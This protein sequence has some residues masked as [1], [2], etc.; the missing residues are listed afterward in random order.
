MKSVNVPCNSNR[1]ILFINPSGWQ[2]ES[3]NIGISYLASSLQEKD[4]EVLILDVNRY[5]LDDNEMLD[6]VRNFDPFL[7][8]I[9]VKTATAVEGGR[10]ADRIAKTLPDVMI[11]AGGPHVTLCSE[12]YLQDNPAVTLGVLG[13]A[14]ES[15]VDL[16]KAVYN[17]ESVSSLKGIATRQGDKI[18]V[19]AWSPPENLDNLKFPNLDVIDDFSWEGYRYPIISSRGCPF[20]CTYCCVNKLTGSRKWRSRSPENVVGEIEMISRTKGITSFELW[21]DN[22]TLDV[23][24]AKDIC[25]LLINRKLNLS[26]YCHNGIRAD[27]IDLELARLMKEAGCTSIAFGMESGNPAVFDSIKKGEPL[28]A[29]VNAVRIAKKAGIEV[30]GYFIIGL[31]G[32]TLEKFIDTVRFQR[33]L[34]LNHYVYGM[35]IP[36]PKTEVWDVIN[37][38]GTLLCDIT[39]TQHFSEDV[40]PVSFEL[41]EFPRKDMVR[42]YYIS[43]YMEIFEALERIIR[44]GSSSNVVYLDADKY[45]DHIAGVVLA[46]HKGTRHTVVTDMSVDQLNQIRGYSQVPRETNIITTRSFSK[47]AK[48]RNTLFVCSNLRIPRKILLR[49]ANLVL[50]NTTRSQLLTIQVRRYVPGVP[51]PQVAIAVVGTILALPGAV[52]LFGL[53]KT[54]GVIR[55][56]VIY[57]FR[58]LLHNHKVKKGLFNSPQQKATRLGTALIELDKSPFQLFKRVS[59]L[60]LTTMIRFAKTL[61]RPL[62]RVATSL[63]ASRGFM[64]TKAQ[65][66]L[67]RHKNKR[68]NYDDYSSYR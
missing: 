32:D 12:S 39:E 23:K 47:F 30:V 1:R 10:I 45:L 52:R 5:E 35:L 60:F 68:F 14:E 36:Y 37:D 13:E 42:A 3:I 28:S 53:S 49:N 2:K 58:S 44:K 31:P 17:G 19:N 22:L 6:R 62:L 38:V 48:N 21:D 25:R 51:L 55:T 27:R 18:A 40:V 26:W 24:R 65:L 34:Q 43:R 54:Y 41:P 7:I 57:A 50:I 59:L 46:C 66:R 56:R 15:I 9:S 8:G 63:W 20:N 16:V 61:P 29:V 11:V 67:R 4:F 33:K 64:K